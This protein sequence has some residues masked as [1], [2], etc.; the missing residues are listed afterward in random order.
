MRALR[1]HRIGAAALLETVPDPVPASAGERLVRM[2]ATAI[3]HHD[4]GVVSG[5]LPVGQPVPFIPGM[6]GAGRLE[7]GTLVRVF[8]GGLGITRPG[9]WAEAVVVPSV[10]IVPVPQSMPAEVAAAC[11]SSVNTA[12]VALHQIGGL[13]EGESVA[14][15]GCNGSVGSLVVQMA[16]GHAVHE[17]GRGREADPEEPVDLLVDT[18][19]GPD[20][21]HRIGCVKPGGRAVLI[22]YTAGE[23]VELDLPA[24]MQADVALLPMNMRRRRVPP[25]VAASLLDDVAEGRLTVATDVITV[26]GL[27][28]GLARLRQDRHSG[29]LVLRW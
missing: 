12:W 5:A 6:E 27:E 23:R 1:V 3:A 19:G 24:L 20:L 26:D 16:R 17:W 15:S 21:P 10:A 2:E 14:V 7:D 22:G 18:V 13:R 11:G 29:R 25:E 28:A 8:G 4:L 9:T